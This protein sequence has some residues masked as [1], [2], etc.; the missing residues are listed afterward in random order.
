[1]NCQWCGIEIPKKEKYQRHKYCSELCRRWAKME[2]KI[3]PCIVCGRLFIYFKVGQPILFC[4]KKCRNIK[5]KIDKDKYDKGLFIFK[6]C[7]QCGKKYKGRK[8]TIFCSYECRG[9]STQ[10]NINRIVECSACGKDFTP[11]YKEQKN[12]SKECQIKATHRANK[13]KYPDEYFTCMC[14]FCG[15]NYQNKRR[16]NKEG[17]KFCSRECAYKYMSVI[18]NGLNIITIKKPSKELIKTIDTLWQLKQ[19]IKQKGE[20]L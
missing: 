8:S 14:N 1:M 9:K 4:S 19:T 17:N 10:S 5:R 18:G 7:P 13:L 6:I 11:H 15:E 16:S 3:K 2:S 20:S 12:C